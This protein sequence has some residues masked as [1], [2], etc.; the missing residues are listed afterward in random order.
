MAWL[1][2]KRA[3]AIFGLLT[4]CFDVGSDI[5][6][7]IDLFQRCHYWYAV[8]TM[9]LICMPGFITGWSLFLN[10]QDLK[11]F[12]VAL[13]GPILMIPVTLYY[14]FE[15]VIKLDSETEERR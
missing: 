3:L 14:Q 15:N 4:Y 13:F 10:G 5:W 1:N 6:V 12:F 11:R 9:L 2:I 8:T 7:A